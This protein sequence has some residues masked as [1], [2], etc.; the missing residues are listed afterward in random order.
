MQSNVDIEISN[1]LF[2][3]CG[4][5]GCVVSG[6]TAKELLAILEKRTVFVLGMRLHVLI[7]AFAA[8]R[9]MIAISYDP[10]VRSFM[11]SV[12]MPYCVEASDLDSET[13]SRMLD[14]LM[15]ELPA[16]TWSMEDKLND[17][18]LS[19]EKDAQTAIDLAV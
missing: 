4:K 11:D 12:N 13:L 5:K 7:Y 14:S 10:K 18:R 19:A 1:K 16:I 9:P 15:E 17:M 8:A 2:E 3:M 6:V